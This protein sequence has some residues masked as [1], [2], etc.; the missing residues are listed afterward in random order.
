[1]YCGN[2][3]WDVALQNLN[4][5]MRESADVI[6]A[7]VVTEGDNRLM[8]CGIVEYATAEGAKE[9]ISTELRGRMIGGGPPQY[10]AGVEEYSIMYGV[11]EVVWR[12]D[13]GWKWR[14]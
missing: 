12:C 2:L 10:N 14:R 1:M 11:V 8:G 7:E 9:I 3:S 5:R 4:D 6:Y 13:V